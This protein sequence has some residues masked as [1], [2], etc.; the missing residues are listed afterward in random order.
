[1][2][3]HKLQQRTDYTLLIFMQDGAPPNLTNSVKNLLNT[4]PDGWIGRVQLNGPIDF[5]LWGTMKDS[6]YNSKTPYFG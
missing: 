4:L 1:M 3:Y 6:V 2:F 5:F